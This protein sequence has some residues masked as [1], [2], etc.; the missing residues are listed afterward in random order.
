MLNC[1][2]FNLRCC[3]SAKAPMLLMLLAI[4]FCVGV[5]VGIHNVSQHQYHGSSE[6]L[7]LHQHR[8]IEPKQR[9][10][11]RA[12]KPT[13]Q[14]RLPGE[15]K[16]KLKT[17]S[18]EGHNG[19]NTTGKDVQSVSPPTFGE[20]PRCSIDALKGHLPSAIKEMLD[21]VDVHKPL[22]QLELSRLPVSEG[23]VAIT[24]DAHFTDEYVPRILEV[25]KRYD[26]CATFFVTGHWADKFPNALRMITSRG[27]EIGNH[28]YSHPKLTSLSDDAIIA[29]VKRAEQS[30]L[31]A[32]GNK[33]QLTPYVRPP[34]GDRDERVVKV[35]LSSG[36]IP[37]YWAVD[38]L[39]WKKGISE[40]EVIEHVVSK[41]SPGDIVLLHATSP[42]TSSA[43]PRLIEGLRLKGLQLCSVTELI[44]R[45]K[46]K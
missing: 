28:T 27:H 5:Y 39:D 7:K 34:Y 41:S 29:E 8:A 6:R 18:T 35:L 38:G 15:T 24:F 45:S 46:E 17:E 14:V 23:L 25:L 33:A 11:K 9:S 40:D 20:S 3:G 19:E 30:I 42:I 16:T 21:G 31:K 4:S 44:M 36:Y 12:P 26:V 10:S 1:I 32:V 13:G 37:T 43:L 22:W 2:A